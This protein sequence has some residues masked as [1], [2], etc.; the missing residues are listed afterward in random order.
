MDTVYGY[1]PYQYNHSEDLGNQMYAHQALS[2]PFSRAEAGPAVMPVPSGA[3]WNV[4]GL[5][6]GG[7]GAAP[8]L[9]TFTGQAPAAPLPGQCQALTPV[10]H[11]KRKSLDIEPVIPPKQLITEEKMAAHLNGLHISSDF[12]SHSTGDELMDVGMD[13]G[14]AAVSEKLK[15]HK[16]VLAE[17]IKR[18][19]SEPL[20]PAA[21]IERLEKPCMSLVVWKPKESLL[22]QPL[23]EEDEDSE[24]SDSSSNRHGKRNGVLVPDLGMD[25]ET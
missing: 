8:G 3:P 22:D 16:I 20:L 12:V 18:I 15:G 1:N 5:P 4:Q 24:S 14:L 17:E 7:A 9:V 13:G 25:V 2:S 19:R 6:W 23:P 10:V 11:T 21:L